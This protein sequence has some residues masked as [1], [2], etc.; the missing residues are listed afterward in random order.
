MPTWLQ[1]IIDQLTDIPAAA[2]QATFDQLVS[3]EMNHGLG[4]TQPD[5]MEADLVTYKDEI[6]AAIGG[7]PKGATGAT[8]GTSSTGG[9]TGSTGSTSTSSSR[10][11]S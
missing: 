7:T 3:N 4:Q 8:G 1:A 5:V 10:A 9:A 6:A 11:S 2:K